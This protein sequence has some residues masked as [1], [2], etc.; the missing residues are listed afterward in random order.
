M[1]RGVNNP[2]AIV[3]SVRFG[4]ER[5]PRYQETLVASRLHGDGFGTGIDGRDFQNSC[6]SLLEV[7]SG[8][9]GA[10]THAQVYFR[11]PRQAI[12]NCECRVTGSGLAVDQ[13]ESFRVIAWL[14]IVVG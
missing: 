8:K 10:E 13:L 1:G 4:L 5:T 7:V 12:Y 6:I 3:N 11:W 9:W 2:H 14:S